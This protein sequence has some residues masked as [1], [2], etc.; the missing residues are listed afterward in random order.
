VRSAS[1]ILPV[2]GSFKEAAIDAVKVRAG[3]EHVAV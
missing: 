3:E 2:D 1:F